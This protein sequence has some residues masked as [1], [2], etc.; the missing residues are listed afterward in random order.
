MTTQNF[1][2]Q[3]SNMPSEATVLE[4]SNSELSST[5][6]AVADNT[7]SA[8]ALDT[9]RYGLAMPIAA[10]VTIT[11]M[12]SMAA[13]V[14]TEFSPQDKSE[15]MAYEINPVENITEAPIEIEAP[16]PLKEIEVPP[17][18]PKLDITKVAEVKVPHVP[19]GDSVPPLDPMELDLDVGLGDSVQIDGEEQPLVRIPPIFP[20]RFLEGNN[21]GY[22]KVRFDVSPQGAPYNVQVTSCTNRTLTRPTIKSVQRWKYRPKVK[23]GQAVARSGLET[24]IR[25]DL[26]DERGQM[27]PLPSGY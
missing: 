12:L 21:S 23:N 11:L 17:P 5:E 8:S 18:P 27:L 20:S 7:A 10:G 26:Q 3:L 16:D 14:T 13:L 6:S 9:A 22:C 2:S 15:T 19:I 25:F 4:A 24:T 1:E